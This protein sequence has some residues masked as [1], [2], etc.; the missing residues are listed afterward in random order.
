MPRKLYL[1]HVRFLFE[2]VALELHRCDVSSTSY[3]CESISRKNILHQGAQKVNENQ[4]IATHARP[5]TSYENS[6]LVNAHIFVFKFSFSQIILTESRIDCYTISRKQTVYCPNT[7][8]L[9]DRFL[10]PNFL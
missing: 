8:H 6:R 7:D 2:S 10:F 3:T 5:T 9:Y 1:S 4:L